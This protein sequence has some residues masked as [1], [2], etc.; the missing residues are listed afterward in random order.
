MTIGMT[1]IK[2]GESAKSARCCGVGLGSAKRYSMQILCGWLAAKRTIRSIGTTTSAFDVLRI[3]LNYPSSLVSQTQTLLG[4]VAT[5]IASASRLIV[6]VQ[7]DDGFSLTRGV[8]TP[9]TVR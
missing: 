1:V 8:A 5:T 3:C 6:V 4:G 9:K 2:Q 7:L